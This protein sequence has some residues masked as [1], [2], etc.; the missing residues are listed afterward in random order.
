MGFGLILCWHVC[1]AV[2]GYLR[3]MARFSISSCVSFGVCAHGSGHCV[4]ENV[5]AV[6]CLWPCGPQ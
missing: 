3:V 4:S 1:T 6:V 5:F 2:F